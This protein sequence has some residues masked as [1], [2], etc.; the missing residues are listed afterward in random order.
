MKQ[1]DEKTENK[2]GPKSIK[3][4]REVHVPGTGMSVTA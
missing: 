2:R 4:M 1:K 3:K